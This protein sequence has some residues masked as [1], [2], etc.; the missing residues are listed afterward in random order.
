MIC[1]KIFCYTFGQ[2]NR[3]DSCIVITPVA[4]LSN[5]LRA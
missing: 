5:N 1:F 3:G 4:P 2:R